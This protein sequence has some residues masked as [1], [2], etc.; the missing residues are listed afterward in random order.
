MRLYSIQPRFVYDLLQ[1]G[2]A[3]LPRPHEEEGHWLNDEDDQAR[4]AYDWLCEQMQRRGLFR[5]Q[6]QAYPVWAW[7]HWAGAKRARPDLR[8]S[9]LKSWAKEARQVLLTLEVP[10]HEVLLHDYDAWHACLNYWYLARP[11]E[12]NAFERRCKAVGQNFYRQK[13]L[14]DPQLH[15][16]LLRSWEQIFDLDLARKV[17]QGRRRDQVVQATFWALEPWHVQEA[18]EFGCGERLVPLPLPDSRARSASS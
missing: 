11:R 13:P 4:R 17:L 14:P 1:S 5:P 3:F 2:Q 16:E 15:D 9:S 10:D 6:A 12:H 8:T 18:L 7:Y